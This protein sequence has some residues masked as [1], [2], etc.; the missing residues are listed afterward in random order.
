MRSRVIFF[1]LLNVLAGLWLLVAPYVLSY[2]PGS[3]AYANDLLVGAAIAVLAAVRV[4]GAYQSAWIS[5]IVALLGV[6]LIVA[7][8]VLNY[9]QSNPR[10]ND[11]IT[12]AFVVVF[13]VA[14]ALSSPTVVE[15]QSP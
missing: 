11:I 13:A 2:E 14:S 8:F 5:W 12:G 1:S 9:Y 3:A 4:L 7:P 15:N 6:W 10:Y